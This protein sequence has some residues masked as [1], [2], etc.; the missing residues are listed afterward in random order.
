V[1]WFKDPPLSLTVAE[2]LTQGAMHSQ[3]HRGQNATRLRD[4]GGEPPTTDYIVWL[5]KGRP[6]AD[7]A[8]PGY[9]EEWLKPYARCSPRAGRTPDPQAVHV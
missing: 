5:W 2:A 9:G 1:P 7:W 4:L 3:Y 6:Q 8:A